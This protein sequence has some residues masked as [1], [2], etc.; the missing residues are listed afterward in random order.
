MKKLTML[1]AFIAIVGVYLTSAQTVQISGTVTSSEDGQPLPGASVQVKGTTVGTT[2][3]FQGKYSLSVPS[4]AQ[5]LVI[6]FVGMKNQEFSLGGGKQL[7]DA[8]LSPD[9]KQ[10]DEIVVTALGIS[11]EKK[12]LGYTVQDLKAAEITRAGNAN[13]SEALQ[14]KLSGIDIKP[15]SGM[16]GASSQIIIRGSRSFSGNNTPLYVI[17]GM[18]VSSTAD[19]ST[20]DGVTGADIANRAI[21]I[22][23]D[24]IESFNVLKGQAAAA[25]YGIRASNGVIVITTKSGRNNKQGK[26]IV[27]ISHTSTFD[28]VSRIPDY[29][30]TYAQ[31]SGGVFAPVTSLS[32]GPKISD[33]SKDPVYGGDANGNPGLYNQKL[34][35]GTD[36]WLLPKAHN[37]FKKFFKTG[38]TSTENIGISQGDANGNYALNLSN[39]AQ[40]GIA[41]STGMHRWNVKGLMDRNLGKHFKVGLNA[42]YSKTNIDKLAGANDTELAGVYAAPSSYNLKG[43]PHFD[44]IDPYKQISYRSLTFDN[45]YWAVEHNKFNE[46]NER[47]L[48]NGHIA[49]TTKLSD[50]MNLNVNY[51]LGID[52]YTT[53]FQDLFSYGHAGK[54]GYIDNYGVSSSTYNSLLTATYDWSIA[55]DLQFT[56]LLGNEIDH[57]YTKTYTEHGEG[58]NFGG[59]DN[60]ANTNTITSGET[61]G[62]N[63]SVGTFGN[64]S[65]SW[66]SM[67]YLNVTGRNDVVSS[68]P[69]NHRTF[70]YPSVSLG[71]IASE[72]QA[73]KNLDWISYAK[74]RGSYAEVGQAGTYVPDYYSKPGYGGGWWNGIPVSYPIDGI[75]SY[76]PYSIKYDPH[77][78]PQNT[79]SYEAGFELKFF[80]NRLGLDYTYSRQNVTD[81]IFSVPLAG[82][83][84]ATSL[85]MNGGKLHTNGH[86]VVFYVTPLKTKSFQ[87]DIKVN[88]SKITNEVDELAPGV[89]SIFLGGF[90]TPQVRASKG[91]T[92]P[93]IFGSSFLRDKAG[94]IVVEDN[95]GSLTNGMPQ[96][97]P[98]AVIGSVSPD[99]IMGGTTSFTY[100]AISLS[101]VFEWKSGGKMYS[102]TNGLL[103]YYGMSAR[104]KDRESTFVYKGVKP[105]GTP[106]DIV[107]GGSNDPR[108]MEILQTQVLTNI[109]ENSVRDNSF[110]KLREISLRYVCPK[111]LFKTLDVSVSAFARNIL[112]WT[113]LENLDPE[114]SQG[115]TNM[116]GS[117]ERLSMPQAT[118]YG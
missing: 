84:G 104:T 85:V 107:R 105:D 21:D 42:S 68:M 2:T 16:P 37:N 111:K 71:F 34:S 53:H 108:A 14:G 8:V 35:N 24:D 11:R 39:T 106:N 44:P 28:N 89:E 64:L 83:T 29:Q 9:V 10:V 19:F 91:A 94:N 77:L 118:S 18:P 48:G 5:I 73:I 99:F 30:T 31:G 101:A 116:G 58:F 13:L 52:E 26:P 110:V 25:L 57:T 112:V 87:W 4:D 3:D 41:P 7:I 54:T 113:K 100:Q 46:I 12:S 22:N 49:Y 6:S 40:D 80:K 86:E 78:K 98:D 103:D 97:G 45:P 60:I 1:L 65:L 114:S 51:Q 47:F 32:W 63:R 66:K 92:Y 93:V 88:Y 43:L 75:N 90:T 38:Y 59:W 50:N 67:L 61:K 96:I 109:D 56:F 72:I 74:V 36:V 69:T 15:S 79:I 27:N 102:G 117:F 115:N 95:P 17:D 20:G 33:L 62:Q 23:P 76:A 82:S 81:Q 55:Q 70:F